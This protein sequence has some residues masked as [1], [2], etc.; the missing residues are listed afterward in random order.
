M[1]LGGDEQLNTIADAEKIRDELL[2]VVYGVWDHIKNGG[3][4]G[5]ENCELDW[6]GFLPGKR[7]SRRFIGDYVLTANDLEASRQFEDVIAVYYIF[8]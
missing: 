8:R 7:E 2:K 6:I 3:D 1:E 5:A 4:H